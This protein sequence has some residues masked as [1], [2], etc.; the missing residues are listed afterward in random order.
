MLA[1]GRVYGFDS[2]GGR[3]LVSSDGKNW[4]TQSQLELLSLAVSPHQE[5]HLLGATAMGLKV[6]RDG[7]KSWQTAGGPSLV[8]LA[9]PGSARLFGLDAKGGVF[10]SEDAGQSWMARGSLEGV[11]EAFI[12]DGSRL[13]A[14]VRERGIFVSSDDGAT[15]RPFYLTGPDPSTR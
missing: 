1:H 10:L 7:G 15:W 14:A 4:Q 13:Y 12:V 5:Q 11:P 3:L 9:W 2:T 6:S 8:L